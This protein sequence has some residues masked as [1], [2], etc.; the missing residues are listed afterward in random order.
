MVS[1][2]VRDVAVPRSKTLYA[3][4]DILA[5]LIEDGGLKFDYDNVPPYHCNIRGWPHEKS[6][7]KMIAIELAEASDL[8]MN[9]AGD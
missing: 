9:P 8:Y 3:R 5:E 7:R 4:G 6:E 1:K 2:R